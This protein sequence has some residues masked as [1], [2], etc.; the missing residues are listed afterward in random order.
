[1]RFL[2]L[3]IGLLLPISAPAQLTP[4]VRTGLD[5]ALYLMQTHSLYA[6]R[7]NWPVVRDSVYQKAGRARTLEEAFPAL[8][9]AFDQ[10]RDKHG[11]LAVESQ[12]YRYAEPGVDPGQRLSPGIRQEYLK[13]PR[14]VTAQ[15]APGVGYLKIPQMIGTARAWAD[16]R[17]AA[18]RDSLCRLLARRPRALVIDL[19]MNG[20]GNSAPMLSGLGPLL[21]DGVKTY[22]IDRNGQVSGRMQLVGGMVVD[23]R[24]APVLTPL[25]ACAVP[26][27]LP[28][29][30]LVGPGTGSSGEILALALRDRPRTPLIGEPTSG[31]L[32]STA[33]FFF[34]QQSGYLLLTTDNMAPASKRPV[35]SQALTP[36]V[37]VKSADNYPNLRAD[38]TVQAAL[39]WLS[40]P[41]HPNKKIRR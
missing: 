10:L 33:G 5:S 32:S 28:V 13:G 2:A 4:A 20:G 41:T 8:R 35:L 18:L 37:Y 17:A 40:R 1:M 31:Y 38:P 26:P 24:G 30:V 15:L 23:E 39:R 36:D 34:G 6:Q 29:V 12:Q 11:M 19:R 14:L 16:G 3:S 25:P 27:G 22:T 21:G 9:Y 7:V